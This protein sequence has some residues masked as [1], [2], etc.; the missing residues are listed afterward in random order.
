MTNLTGP[1]GSSQSVRNEGGTS[2]LA[3]EFVHPQSSGANPWQNQGVEM[4]LRARAEE[5]DLPILFGFVILKPNGEDAQR[6]TRPSSVERNE[7]CS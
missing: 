7:G 6:K 2:N 3:L 5:P 4:F 1:L